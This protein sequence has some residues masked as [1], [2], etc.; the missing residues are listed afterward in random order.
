MPQRE[1]IPLIPEEQVGL[2]DPNMDDMS[3]SDPAESGIKGGMVN[4]DAI[5]PDQG[6]M[7]LVDF[8]WKHRNDQSKSNGKGQKSKPQLKTKNFE[9]YPVVLRFKL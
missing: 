6:P 2:V 3:I 5:E 1:D 9:L 4:K 8:L 7:S